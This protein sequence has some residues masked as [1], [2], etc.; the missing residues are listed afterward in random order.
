MAKTPPPP[1]PR[2]HRAKA[3]ADV[4]RE[5][6]TLRQDTL[7]DLQNAD[8]KTADAQRLAEQDTRAA[9]E[10]VTVDSVV[11]EV[12]A[13]GLRVG[14]ALS[15]LSAQ[16]VAEVR[17]LEQVRSVLALERRELERLHQ[18]D[19]AATAIDM[20]VQDYDQR[21][22]ALD[23][24]VSAA[25]ATWDAEESER[26]RADKEF[27]DALKKQRQREAEDFEYRKA[28]ER[29]KAQD[30]YDEEQRLVEKKNRERQDTLEK[31]WQEREAALKA[32]ED[33]L[34]RLKKEVDGFPQ[35]L[36]D[37][38]ARA[39]AETTAAVRRDAEQQ[40][41]LSAKDRESESRVAEL[42]IRT[43]EETLARQSQQ[44][45]AL[46]KQVD[47]AK[48]QVQEIAVKAIEGAS[49]AR[50]LAHVNQIAIEQAKT[51]SPQG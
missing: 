49:G 37:D 11:Q 10:G 29:K 44:I 6:A 14:N 5:F 40:V 2:S 38:V 46:Q 4:D 31:S 27:D 48:Q 18:I 32:Q 20:L 51:R 7:A 28:L 22:R 21:K 39:V 47:E 33:E 8:K 25:R 43:H 19:I 42:T 41:Q 9:I 50:A 12:A 23:G 36:H 26:A 15:D 24:E 34:K 1:P 16:L 30:K 13:L 45:A 17:Q 3:K 35:R